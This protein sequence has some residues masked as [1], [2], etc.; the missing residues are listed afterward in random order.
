MHQRLDFRDRQPM[1]SNRY[2]TPDGQLQRRTRALALLSG[3]QSH[4][5]TIV[6]LLL[7]EGH[8]CLVQKRAEPGIDRL[9]D[10][11]RRFDCVE[12]EISLQ[13]L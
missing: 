10:V 7:F 4:W 2:R 13:S 6:L 11:G 8:S 3:T 12:I 9:F 1:T 5:R